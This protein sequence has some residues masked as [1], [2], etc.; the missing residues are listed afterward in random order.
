MYIKHS[1]SWSETSKLFFFSETGYEFN[2]AE[3]ELAY[4]HLLLKVL[5]I[6]P[7][8]N[9]SL[10]VA[11]PPTPK[12]FKYANTCFSPLTADSSS[13]L[14]QSECTSLKKHN[15]SDNMLILSQGLLPISNA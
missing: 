2:Y 11:K 1:K 8:K 12:S 10:M 7:K 14:S 13:S 9:G 5:Q 15:Y 3:T 4:A 6:L